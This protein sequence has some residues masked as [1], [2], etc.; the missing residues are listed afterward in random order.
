MCSTDIWS[1][2]E[3]G[4]MHPIFPSIRPDFFG[5]AHNPIFGD[6][7]AE[8]SGFLSH[9]RTVTLDAEQIHLKLPFTS[10]KIQEVYK[11]P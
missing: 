10:F 7:N 2:V 8:F 5:E 6:Q 9:I 11:E 4:V 3:W 1:T